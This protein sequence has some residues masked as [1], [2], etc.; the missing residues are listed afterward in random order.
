MTASDYSINI[1]LILKVKRLQTRKPAKGSR[2]KDPHESSKPKFV[3]CFL[4][5]GSKSV[6]YEVMLHINPSFNVATSVSV[7]PMF[8]LCGHGLGEECLSFA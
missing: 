6:F 8:V 4:L 7:S 1:D 5:A 3:A 2:G